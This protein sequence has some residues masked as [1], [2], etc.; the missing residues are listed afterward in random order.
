MGKYLRGGGW[1]FTYSKWDS[2]LPLT[3]PTLDIGLTWLP[4][5]LWLYGL[6]VDEF[7]RTGI[8]HRPVTRAWMIDSS[9]L[10]TRP[11]PRLS[12]V[13]LSV[14]RPR[15]IKLHMAWSL[16]LLSRTVSVK[17]S[18]QK[19]LG[20]RTASRP[21]WRFASFCCSD[22]QYWS[23]LATVQTWKT[24][25]TQGFLW[26]WKTQGIIREFCATSGK[27]CN[28][29]VRHSNICVKLLFWTSNEQSRALLTWSECGADVFAGVCMEWP[30]MK[31]VITI[32]FCWDNL[33]ETKFM[34]L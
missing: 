12:A 2:L 20:L 11:D 27:N 13:C 16:F 25:N 22:V 30:L 8:D 33:W 5:V 9:M 7:Q 14:S 24:W 3:Y 32:T 23:R 28:I 19:H 34:A 31:F 10:Q 26:T 18:H 4:S 1:R 17:Y 21:W 29:F 6:Y 15:E